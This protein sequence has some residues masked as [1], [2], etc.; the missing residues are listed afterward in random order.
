MILFF[1][2]CRVPSLAKCWEEDG[3][4]YMWEVSMCTNTA[5][6]IEKKKI[7]KYCNI[8]VIKRMKTF[9]IWEFVP[10]YHGITSKS[11]GC[12]GGGN[13]EQWLDFFFFVKKLMANISIIHEEAIDFF[14]WKDWLPS[15]CPLQR[16]SSLTQRCGGQGVHARMHM[17]GLPP[18]TC[19]CT[20]CLCAYFYVTFRPFTQIR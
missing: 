5:R 6:T 16:K 15:T 18:C 10:S 12:A 13:I 7:P 19:L 3:R 8:Y 11:K 17:D 20:H 14:G 9:N 2:N 1:F 4:Y